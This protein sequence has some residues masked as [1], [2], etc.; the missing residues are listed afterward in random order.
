MAAGPP[1]DPLGLASIPASEGDRKKHHRQLRPRDISSH[2]EA[3]GPDLTFRTRCQW[4]DV[5]R[6]VYAY[7]AMA[8]T[9]AVE[10]LGKKDRVKNKRGEGGRLR[11]EMIEAAGRL[12]EDPDELAGLSFRA[13]AREVGI[14]P[15]S[16]Y[17]HFKEKPDLVL[18][19]I[20]E[21]LADLEAHLERARATAVGPWEQL[22]ARCLAYCSWG[23]EHPGQYR[24]V[25]ESAVTR[26]AGLT[27]QGSLGAEVF[28]GLVD[29]VTACM[30]S[31]DIPKSNAFEVATDIWIAIH[32]IVSLVQ[33]KPSFPWPRLETLVER[34]L[35]HQCC[36]LQ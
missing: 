22:V 15:Q 35:R 31:G 18:A 5:H 33:S 13:V 29:A 2:P 6:Q 4:T 12:L 28:S 11:D 20:D 1:R 14:T 10:A 24:M 8:T 9:A 25:F 3:G 23:L 26:Q 16:V 21:R 36:K 30:D 19:V 27:V 32:G 17:L 34:N 7:A